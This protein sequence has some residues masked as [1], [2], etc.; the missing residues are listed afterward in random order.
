MESDR[1]E[2]STSTSV[3]HGGEHVQTTLQ[4]RS[5]INNQHIKGYVT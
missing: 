2:I 4:N 1:T 3:P 5:H